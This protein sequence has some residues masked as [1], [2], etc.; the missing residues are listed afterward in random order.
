MPLQAVLL[1]QNRCGTSL[2]GSK[3]SDKKDTPASLWNSEVLS[4]Q[5]SPREIIPEL[6]QRPD[7]AT[8]VPSFATWQ[9]S[10]DIFPHDPRRRESVSKAAKLK[11]EVATFI[12]QSSSESRDGE[13]LARGSSHKNVN[14]A[15]LKAAV[16]E[17]MGSH[18][19]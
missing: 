2:V 5:D 7:D 3:M 4:V 8:K 12:I 10:R 18:I 11:G 16:C 9:D 6:A 13:G 1:K 14:W 17:V 15:L 19:S